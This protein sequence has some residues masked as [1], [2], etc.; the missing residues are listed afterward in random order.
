[1]PSFLIAKEYMFDCLENVVQKI[2]EQFAICK[3][4]YLT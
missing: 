2:E 3:Q 4:I 1:M